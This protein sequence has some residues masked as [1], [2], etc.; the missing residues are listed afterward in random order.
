MLTLE[1]LLKEGINILREKNIQ[2]ASLDAWL[3]LEYVTGKS[4]AYYFAHP[5]DAVAG[6]KGHAVPQSGGTKSAAHSTA[7]PY[8]SGLFYGL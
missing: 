6:E 8:A 5:E 4:R 1:T 2:E 7:A 3:L